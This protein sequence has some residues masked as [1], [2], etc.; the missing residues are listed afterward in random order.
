MASI[1]VHKHSAGVQACYASVA[2][3]A[4]VAADDDHRETVQ[5]PPGSAGKGSCAEHAEPAAEDAGPAEPSRSAAAAAAGAATAD[6]LVLQP[7]GGSPS[8][9]DIQHLHATQMT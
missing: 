3:A 9:L 1:L 6:W 7:A 5:R 2:A 8:S 4:A